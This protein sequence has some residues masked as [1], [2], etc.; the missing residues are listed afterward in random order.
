MR[1]F[2]E[3]LRKQGYRQVHVGR[4]HVTPEE[5]ALVGGYDEAFTEPDM[6]EIRRQAGLEG[7]WTKRSIA[8]PVYLKRPGWEDWLVSA[9]LTDKEELTFEGSVCSKAIDKL[10]DLC[11]QSNPWHLSVNFFSPHDPY[12][13]PREYAEMYDPKDI[14]KPANW[15]DDMKDK[16]ALYRRHR[17]ELWDR[18]SWEEQA[19]SI[20]RYWGACT[21]IDDCVGRLLNVLDQSGQASNTLVIYTSDHGDMMGGHGLFL[22]GI[23]PFEE[24][25][26]VPLIVRWPERVSPRGPISEQLVSLLDIAPTIIN[27]A[28]A[29]IWDDAQG[30]PLQRLVD[31]GDAPKRQYFYGEFHGG[32]YYYTQ[33]I[34]WNLRHKF[35]FNSFDEDELYDLQSDPQEEHN[36][37][38]DPAV[39]EVKK[40]MLRLY[41]QQHDA[42]GDFLYLNYPSIALFSEGPN[43]SK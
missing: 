42:T 27:A 17:R 9:V 3:P 4:W 7:F 23:M 35:V 31:D 33:R 21:Y 19:K 20:A 37:I 2:T 39:A 1:Y 28:N 6:R 14:P 38:N 41:W 5:N 26:R 43:P 25:W 40:Q 24:T 29:D 10:Q 8:D 12:S 13:C 15:N 18:L 34:V 11:Q 16:P 36:L 30:L 32:E 22:K